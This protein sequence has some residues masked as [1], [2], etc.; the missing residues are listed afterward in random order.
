MSTLRVGLLLVLSCLPA[1]A[2]EQTTVEEQTMD[3]G[4]GVICDTAPQ[5]ERFA[6]LRFGGKDAALALKT[7]NDDVKGVRAC[8]FALVMFTGG[9]PVAQLSVNGRPVTVVKIIVHAI[10]YGFAWKE[11]PGVVRYT[12]AVEK[13]RIA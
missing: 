11:V 9:A 13:G 7:V 5:A 4:Q 1:T 8:D 6:E 12:V 2:Q 10:G 3:V